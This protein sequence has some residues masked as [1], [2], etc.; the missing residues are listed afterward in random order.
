MPIHIR[1]DANNLVPTAGTTHLPEQKETHQLFHVLR[2]ESNSG[3]LD[4]LAH[5]SSKYCLADVLTKHPTQPDELIKALE[6]GNLPEVDI[7][8]PFRELLP[9]KVFAVRWML[10]YI[11]NGATAI[12]MLGVDISSDIYQL[13]YCQ[14]IWW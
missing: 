5:V 14:G 8:P 13:F 3:V 4:D 10:K 7:H 11:T 2:K 6:T 1:T 12:A 9:H